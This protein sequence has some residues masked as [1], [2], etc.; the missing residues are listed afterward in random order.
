MVFERPRNRLMTVVRSTA[1]WLF[2]FWLLL[3]FCFS[4][5]DVLAYLQDPVTYTQVYR[6]PLLYQAVMWGFAVLNGAG[7]A[8]QAVGRRTGR[9]SVV[10]LAISAVFV[11][12]LFVGWRFGIFETCCG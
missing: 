10:A 3:G 11:C 8:L 9:F 4:V 6:D 1:Y 7:L 5:E 2:L 12:F